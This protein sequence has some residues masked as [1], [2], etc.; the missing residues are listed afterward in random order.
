MSP[1]SA[2]L[3][4]RHP[5]NLVWLPNRDGALTTMCRGAVLTIEHRSAKQFAWTVAVDGLSVSEGSSPGVE[6]AQDAAV[7]AAVEMVGGR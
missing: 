6:H 1:M 4:S 7:D 2:P 5:R 3:E